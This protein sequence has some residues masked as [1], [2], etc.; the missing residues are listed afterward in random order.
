MKN[1]FYDVIS[2][3]YEKKDDY[4]EKRSNCKKIRK[5]TIQIKKMCYNCL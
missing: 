1:L 2:Y 5:I 3:F 4:V